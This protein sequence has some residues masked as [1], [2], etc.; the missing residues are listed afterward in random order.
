[1]NTLLVDS[2]FFSTNLD[3]NFS[4]KSQVEAITSKAT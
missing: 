2:Y 4:W 3:A 1:M